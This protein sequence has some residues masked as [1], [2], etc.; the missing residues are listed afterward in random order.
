[1]KTSIVI[2]THNK[3]EYSQKCI[4]SIR[5]YTDANSYELIVVDNNSTDETVAWLKKQKD[6]K[7]I[8]NDKN[9]GFPKGCNQGIEVAT[10]EN[11]L[12][13]NND[14]IV[15]RRWLDNLISCLCSNENIGAVGPVTNNASYYQAIN[16]TYKSVEEMHSF[17]ENFNQSNPSIWEERL[18]LVGFCMLIKR[19]VV[20]KVGL[21]DE[22]FTPGNFEDDDYSIRIRMAGYKLML[23]KDTFIHHFGS[24]S[25]KNDN[26]AYSKLLSDNRK[27]FAE[28]W[29]FDSGYST[30]I[31]HEI[32]KLINRPRNQPIKVLEVGC[33]CGGTLL[34]IKNL[35]KN[36]ELFGIELNE[37]AAKSANI[38]ADVIAADIEKAELPYKRGSFDYIILADVLE[39]LQN[40]WQALQNIKEYLAPNGQVLASIPNVMHFSVVKGLL[41]GNWSYEDAGIL[42]R[43]HLRFF[44]LNEIDKML[45]ELG[46]C[47]KEYQ[48][49]V[50]SETQDDRDFIKK[51]VELIGNPSM[52][53][54]F[55]AYQ[56]IFAA[57]IVNTGA[58][59]DLTSDQSQ[60]DT[61]QKFDKRELIFILR[62]VEN[63]LEKSNSLDRIM[64]ILISGNI[65]INEI[66]QITQNDMI[67]KEELLQ[68]LAVTCYERGLLE[69]ALAFLETAYRWNQQNPITVYNL[70]YILYKLGETEVALR[71]LEQLKEQDEETRAL[72][73]EI[74]EALHE[75][76]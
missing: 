70:S 16:V 62:R 44:T 35:Y 76:Q 75:S 49:T 64:D 25:F 1:M 17:A 42:D 65:T 21:L 72:L 33:A 66:I 60:A 13:L 28:K 26:V 7:A 18:K 4:E 50:F 71:F 3:L 5:Q 10:G 47:V 27:K 51:V 9:L 48:S 73:S 67:K 63:D 8:Y 23:C 52:E 37:K 39:H 61:L 30:I 11:I 43:T 32:I 36:A 69:N 53:Q 54:Q 59:N 12:L 46:Y 41:K 74:R 68:T 29:G 58:G 40:P 56:Y 45:K 14:I 6:I 31:R 2:L 22:L 57:S 34:Q 19:S 24:V 15:T 20:E 38:F 55:R